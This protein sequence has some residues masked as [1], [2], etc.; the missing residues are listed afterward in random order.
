M[1]EAVGT[2]GGG[3]GSVPGL[4]VLAAVVVAVLARPSL[5]A[6]AVRQGLR[7]AEPRW[8][9]RPPWLP[10]PAQE[11][12]HFRLVTAYGDE[13]RVRPSELARDVVAYLR[14]CRGVRS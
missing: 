8:W 12:V 9:R 6:V 13:G 14:W 11:Y 5:W 1:T 4:R 2:P 3:A 7:L 10:L